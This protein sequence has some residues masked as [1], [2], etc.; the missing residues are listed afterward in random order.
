MG[1]GKSRVQHIKDDMQ[2]QGLGLK[3]GWTVAEERQFK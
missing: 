1:S 3:Q 2:R